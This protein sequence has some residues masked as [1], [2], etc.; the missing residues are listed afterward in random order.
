MRRFVVALVALLIGSPLARADWEVKRSPFDARV[1]AR[2][3]QLVHANPDDADALARLT[4]LYKQYKSVDELRRELAAAA[5]KSGDASDFLAVGNL[6]RN[7]GDFAGAAKA[8]AAAL[9]RAPDDARALAALADADVRLGKGGEARPLYERALGQTKDP[10][11]R[12]PLLGKLVDLALAPDR[13]LGAKEAIAEARPW[14]DELVRL[15]PRN[16]DARQRWAEALAA[17][18]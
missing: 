1:V 6:A 16:D 14:H 2:Y 13:G 8:Y 9:E 15:D 5:D 4:A 7:R 11:R 10:T 3:K 12:A 17:H 18:G